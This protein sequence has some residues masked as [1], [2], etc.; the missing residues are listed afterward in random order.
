MSE[1]LEQL[2]QAYFEANRESWKAKEALQNAELAYHRANEK[3]DKAYAA[4]ELERE[5]EASFR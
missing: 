1:Q 4:L 5:K 2:E 3:R